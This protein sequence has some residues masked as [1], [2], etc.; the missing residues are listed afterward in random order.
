MRQM[1]KLVALAILVAACAGDLDGQQYWG[2]TG[3]R[4]YY[5]YR[6][7]HC[8]YGPY[9]GKGGNYYTYYYYYRPN[10]GANYYNYHTCFYYPNTVNNIRG[11]YY[12]YK[13]QITGKYWGRCKPGSSDY[14]RLAE[15]NQGPSL[16]EIAERFFQRQKGMTPV[17]GMQP[18]TLLIPPPMPTEPPAE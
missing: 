10:P 2:K 17:P 8:Y 14:E 3:G 16:N 5:G 4:Y 18:Q 13:N 11:G 7:S 9:R 1:P 15:D 6:N 12:Y